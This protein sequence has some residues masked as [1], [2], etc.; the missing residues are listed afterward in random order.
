MERDELA[1]KL[2]SLAQLDTDAVR[3]YD[4]AL[5]HVTDDEV[6]KNFEK[7][8]SE[9]RYH[10]EQLSGTI[11]RLGERKPEL[12]LDIAG[13]FAD[14]VTSIRSRTGTEGALHAMET[15]ERYHNR[16]YAEAAMWV[17]G[18]EEIH[19]LL[20]RFDEDEKRHLA[21]VE[22]RLGKMARSERA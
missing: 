22:E 19:T 11:E 13:H 14:W 18:D 7:F 15:A 5:N 10:A 3:V 8:R 20:E 1:R 4:D 16:H 12:S 6:R 21:Y 2:R 17:T 9:H